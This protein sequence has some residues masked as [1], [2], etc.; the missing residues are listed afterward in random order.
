LPLG[1]AKLSHGLD[2]EV[3]KCFRK[4]TM[5]EDSIGTTLVSIGSTVAVKAPIM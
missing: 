5:E 2:L 4:S 1:G 3:E